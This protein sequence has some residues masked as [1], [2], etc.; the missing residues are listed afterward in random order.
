M[1]NVVNDHLALADKKSTLCSPA[2]T[3]TK[4]GKSLDPA[5]PEFMSHDFFCDESSI[6][7]MMWY[8]RIIGMKLVYWTFFQKNCH[9]ILLKISNRLCYMMSLIDLTGAWRLGITL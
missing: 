9:F 8:C 2:P 6:M 5:A 7:C 3:P 4:K 1:E